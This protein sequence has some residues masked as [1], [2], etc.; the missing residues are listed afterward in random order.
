MKPAD[1]TALFFDQLSGLV[2]AHVEYHLP[3]Q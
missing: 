1:W 3:A 2:G